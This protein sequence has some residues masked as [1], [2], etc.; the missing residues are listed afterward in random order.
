MSVRMSLPSAASPGMGPIGVSGGLVVASF[1]AYAVVDSIFF[2]AGAVQRIAYAIVW[3]AS[4][5]A[6]VLAMRHARYDASA[7]LLLALWLLVVAFQLLPTVWQQPLYPA[8]VAGDAASVLLPALVLMLGLAVPAVFG[9]RGLA[10][11]GLCLLSG[12]LLAPVAGSSGSRFE[13]P[14]SFLIALGIWLMATGRR[15]GIVALGSA[16]SAA[17]LAVSLA[18]GQRTSALVWLAVAGCAVFVR[19]GARAFVVGALLILVVIIGPA[20]GTVVGAV[21]SSLQSTRFGTVVGGES[22][23]SLMARVQEGVDV[24]YTLRREGGPVEYLIGFGHGAT[25]KPRFSF[26]ARNVTDEGRVHNI[27]IGPLLLLFRYG[28]LG[29]LLAATLAA[30]A[31][32][33]LAAAG[34]RSGQ[35]R[36]SYA[37]LFALAIVAYLV[38]GLMFNVL[39]DPMFS[40]AL[41]GFLYCALRWSDAAGGVGS[42]HSSPVDGGRS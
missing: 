19:L 26:L 1:G 33:Q 34:R 17:T 40:Y 30:M 18:S 24:V 25:Y 4:I 38:E 32:S 41:A 5:L 23:E 21:Q 10:V 7:W 6:V 28:V 2:G 16:I 37:T 11:L 9:A 8:Y 31:A 36:N 12:M 27:H 14:S 15:A 13:A 42:G 3:A 22:D 35:G 29:L 20:R 39:V